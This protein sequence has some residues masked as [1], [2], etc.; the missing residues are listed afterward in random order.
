MICTIYNILNNQMF[1]TTGEAKEPKIHASMKEADE[2]VKEMASTIAVLKVRDVDIHDLVL[3]LSAES[4]EW[5]C[6]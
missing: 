6:L 1:L 3:T 4:M 2:R 5:R